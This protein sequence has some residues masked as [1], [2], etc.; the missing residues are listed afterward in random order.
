MIERDEI[1][2]LETRAILWQLVLNLLKMAFRHRMPKGHFGHDLPMFF[3]YGSAMETI[4]RRRRVTASAISRQ[5][6]LPRETVRRYLQSLVKLGL[7]ERHNGTFKAGVEARDVYRIEMALRT[8]EQAAAK[9][10]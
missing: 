4:W 7:L 1:A 3:V 2:Y 6:E 10:M 5:L 9:L 8:V